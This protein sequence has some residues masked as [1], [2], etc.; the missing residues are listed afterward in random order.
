M[1]SRR[2]FVKRTAL[3]STGLTVGGA[4]ASAKSYRRIA[5]ANDRIQIAIIGLGRRL[6][7]FYEP[8]S[9]GGNN[10]ELRYLCDVMPS[11]L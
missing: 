2:D 6:G 11:Q 5:G 9:K 10:V 1:V 8:I 7:A 3:I 4:A